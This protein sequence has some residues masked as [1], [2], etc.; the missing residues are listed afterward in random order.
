MYF[1][2]PKKYSRVIESKIDLFVSR[3]DLR[4]VWTFSPQIVYKKLDYKEEPCQFRGY[5][6]PSL[7]TKKT[8]YCI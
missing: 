8:Y 7:Q 5:Q 3:Y 2:S 1:S 6:D 4:S